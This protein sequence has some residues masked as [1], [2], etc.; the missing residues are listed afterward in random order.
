MDRI[1]MQRHGALWTALAYGADGSVLSVGAGYSE[2]SA[3]ESVLRSRKEDDG[4]SD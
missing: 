1:V 2:A 3:L 4:R